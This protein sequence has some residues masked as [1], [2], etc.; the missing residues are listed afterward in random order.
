MSNIR[1]VYSVNQVFIQKHSLTKIL[2][3]TIIVFFQ[4]YML[5]SKHKV[6]YENHDKY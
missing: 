4:K 5:K 6:Y 1:L 3:N 2:Q